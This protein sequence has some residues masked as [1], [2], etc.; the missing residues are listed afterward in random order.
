MLKF[1]T[2]LREETEK[3][4]DAAEHLKHLPHT[5]DLMFDHGEKG[6]HDAVSLLGKAHEHLTK[7]HGDSTITTKYDG[8]PSVVF[9]HHP[10]TGKFF[11]ATKSAFNK[12]PKLNYTDK[13]I[14][15]NHGH[16]PGLASKM[17]EVL[18][19]LPKVTPKKGVYQGDLMYGK[20]DVKEHK[21]SYHFTPNTITYKTKKDSEEG[22]KIAKSKI[23]FVVHTKYHGPSLDKMK[24]RFDPDKHNFKKHSHVNLIDN[25]M[26]F[27]KVKHSPEN[28][29][30]YKHHM[31]EAQKAYRS[32]P[33]DTFGVTTPHSEHLNTYINHT[34]KT[35]ET[36]STKGYVEHLKQKYQKRA[37]KVKTEKAKAKHLDELKNHIKHVNAHKD[38]FDS[39]FKIHHHLEQAKNA[40]VSS[41]S[42]HPKFE[43]SIE[44][45]P[46]DPEGT[47]VSHPEHGMAKLVNRPEFAKA[48]LLKTRNK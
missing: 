5:E 34:V 27:S 30:N 26:D 39:L 10:Q 16:A 1:L 28:E 44:G 6:F 31:E 9:G 19:H 24:A 21:G 4:E 43:H 17:K 41:L 12:T 33:H 8:S 40:L 2:F 42:S 46:T 18:H 20:G 36:P 3:K 35:D 25:E 23:G 45:K 29:K 13:D 47:V 37:D 48:N 14:E 38:R 22:N 7:G 11:V 15:E 32:A